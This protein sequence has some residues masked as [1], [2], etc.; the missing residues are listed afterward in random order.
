MHRYMFSENEEIGVAF[1]IQCIK[2][3]QFVLEHSGSCGD[4]S[5]DSK[6]RHNTIDRYKTAL[7]IIKEISGVE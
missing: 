4:G 5:F 7:S 2:D 3:E 6:D 1:L